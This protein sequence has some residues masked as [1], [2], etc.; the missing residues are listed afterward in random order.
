[1]FY[2]P[3]INESNFVSELSLEELTQLFSDMADMSSSDSDSS[4]FDN[5]SGTGLNK[6]LSTNF[7][8]NYGTPYKEIMR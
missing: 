3:K 1:M 6:N 2:T 5:G 4:S 8:M 7:S